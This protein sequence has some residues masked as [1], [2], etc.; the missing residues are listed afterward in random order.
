MNFLLLFRMPRAAV[1]TKEA[2]DACFRE[3]MAFVEDLKA[4]N[5]L[6]FDSQVL[7]ES[8]ALRFTREAGVT[9]VRPGPF[10]ESPET[11]GGFFVIRTNTRAEAVELAKRCPHQQVGAVELRP[12]NDTDT[13]AY[14]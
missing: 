5:S 2:S 7:A 9:H 14:P 13:N 3:M 6:L 12:L 4:T 1:L 11:I 10:L 8:E